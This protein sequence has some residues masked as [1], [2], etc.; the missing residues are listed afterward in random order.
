MSAALLS[1]PRAIAQKAPI[2]GGGLRLPSVVE[3]RRAQPPLFAMLLDE[4]RQGVLVV[5]ALCRV[6][7]ANR[8]ARDMLPASAVQIQADPGAHEKTRQIGA[9]LRQAI[10]QRER[11]GD[12]ARLCI[13]ENESGTCEHVY[14]IT[15]APLDDS[16]GNGAWCILDDVTEQVLT[17]QIR[18]DFVTNA[19]HELRTPLSLIHGYIETLQ[20]GMI[21]GGAS[22]LRCLEVMEKHSKRMMRIIEDMLT[23]SRLESD[24]AQLKMETFHV[25]ACV[26]DVLEHLTPVVELRQPKITLDFPPDGGLLHG[27]RFYWDQV[28]SNLIEN[29]L[30]ENPC[31]GLQLRISGEWNDQGCVL[32]VS[33][34]G[35]GIPSADLPFVFKRFYR[36]GKNRAHETKGTGLG[37]SIVKRAVEAHGGTI[38]VSSAPGM[39]TK[40]VMS[41]PDITPSLRTSP[42]A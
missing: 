35:I 42:A 26:E 22:L 12:D 1:P 18:R 38:E 40:F 28:F 15:A 10:E 5:D 33:D 29:A 39:E 30:K 27:D 19:S 36:C 23:I 4:T 31:T 17:E 9:L 34:N 16:D 24:D 32:C 3:D 7:Y 13:A 11:V 21:K 20:S 6:T 2:S 8:A 41:V 25:R 14:R 37:L